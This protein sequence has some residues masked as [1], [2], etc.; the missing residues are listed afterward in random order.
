MSTSNGFLRHQ[1]SQSKGTTAVKSN[2]H[3]LLP[4]GGI[5]SS[6]KRE[7]ELLVKA[8]EQ[9]NLEMT[10]IKTSKKYNRFV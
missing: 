8:I 10:K 6:L 9:Q 3:L 2:H 7:I 4:Q 1:L 5:S